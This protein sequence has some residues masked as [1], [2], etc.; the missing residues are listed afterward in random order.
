MTKYSNRAVTYTVQIIE[1]LDN[2]GHTVCANNCSKWPNHQIEVTK[3]YSISIAFK[4]YN[5]VY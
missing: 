4:H 2:R 5:T 3:F 1:G